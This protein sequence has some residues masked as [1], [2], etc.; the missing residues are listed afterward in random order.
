MSRKCRKGV[1]I[2]STTLRN[3]SLTGVC[4]FKFLLQESDMEIKKAKDGKCCS[5]KQKTP[6]VPSSRKK[7][8][9][10]NTKKME[11]RR[12]LVSKNSCSEV[13]LTNGGSTNKVIIY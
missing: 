10:E 13:R 9:M 11:K 6:V 2:L 12:P 7:P 1:Q 3:I 8:N 4:E 5:S